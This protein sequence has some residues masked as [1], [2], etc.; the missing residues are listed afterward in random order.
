M[1]R[2]QPGN[3][4]TTHWSIV[5]AAGKQASPDSQL[6]LAELCEKYWYPPYVYVRRR[7]PDAHEAQDLTQAFFTQLLEKNIV[8]DAD[9]Q[10]GRFRT[11][12][13]A[14]LNHFLSNEWNK[15]RTQKRGGGKPLV[16]LDLFDGERRYESLPAD[17][18]TPERIF[19]RQWVLTL[20]KQVLDR[21]HAE[22]IASG[23]LQQFEHLE[24]SI[25]VVQPRMSYAEL[26]EKTDLSVGAVKV[27]LHR[28]RNR[29]RELLRIEIAQTLA[30]PGGVD[31]EI[32]R[33]FETFA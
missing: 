26:A 10:R 13:L 30:D 8:A 27:S 20:L 24:A 31:D 11:F 32:R 19:D 15:A 25:T 28:L 22:F 5:F 2:S 4:D 14:A 9:P 33:L 23:K 18:L 1:N 16:S 17:D 12:L 6:A 29:Y 21:L 7:I 3:F